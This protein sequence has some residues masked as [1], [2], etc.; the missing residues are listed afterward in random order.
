MIYV[1]ETISQRYGIWV[2][3]RG[4]EMAVVVWWAMI[5]LRE[6]GLEPATIHLITPRHS[7]PQYKGH[8]MTLV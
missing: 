3:E 7:P 6:V 5:T 1:G 8:E 2:G 4:Y